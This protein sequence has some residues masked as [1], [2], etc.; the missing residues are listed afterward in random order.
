MLIELLCGIYVYLLPS[1]GFAFYGWAPL[2]I[3]VDPDAKPIACRTP[4][5]IL[6]PELDVS[7]H[8][9][10]CLGLAMP[11]SRLGLEP[12]KS[13]KMVM[14]RSRHEKILDLKQHSGL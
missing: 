13:G 4:A 10:E 11:M 12:R 5:S 3:H 9:F 14:S 8:L 2:E 6:L 7:R 1:P